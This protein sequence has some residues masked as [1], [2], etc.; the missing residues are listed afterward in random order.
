ML[1]IE[2]I[3]NHFDFDKDVGRD[4]TSWLKVG[5]NFTS[6]IEAHNQLA[7]AIKYKQPITV[8][9]FPYETSFGS[10]G[11]ECHIYFGLRTGTNIIMPNTQG[12]KNIIKETE[13]LLAEYKPD[14]DFNCELCNY[15]SMVTEIKN[16]GYNGV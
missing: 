15:L 6:S 3:I 7:Y 1:N 12:L 2:H 11:V 10:K 16:Q 4:Y 9:V 8:H 14:G 5:D 13:L